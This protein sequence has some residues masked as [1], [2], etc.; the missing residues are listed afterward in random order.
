MEMM[1][2]VLEIEATYV[3]VVEKLYYDCVWLSGGLL[4]SKVSCNRATYERRE[5]SVERSEHRMEV[6]RSEIQRSLQ[7]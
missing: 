2:E 3:L 7:H 4:V 5:G 1:T 6:I